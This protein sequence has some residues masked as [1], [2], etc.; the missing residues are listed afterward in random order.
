MKISGPGTVG[1]TKSI[2]RA[3]QAS[4]SG[5]SFVKHLAPEDANTASISSAN[6]LAAV[7]ALLA[8]QEV[9]DAGDGR[10]RG[11]KRAEE[12]LIGLD[13]IQQGLLMGAISKEKLK[14]LVRA[15]QEKRDKVDDNNLSM[16][17]EE[18]ELRAAVELA[19]LNQLS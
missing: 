12:L 13:Q 19:K 1:S 16:V 17:L 14:D 6:P 8:L 11:L 7:D 3:R 9:S 2:K 15:V 5:E 18:I 4:G 10:S